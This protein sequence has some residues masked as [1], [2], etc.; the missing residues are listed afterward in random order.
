MHMNVYAHINVY[1]HKC[2]RDELRLEKR[3]MYAHAYLSHK[4]YITIKIIELIGYHKIWKNMEKKH[5]ERERERYSL[6][7]TFSQIT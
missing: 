6:Y 3:T 7:L 1:V 4:I 5:R 2:L